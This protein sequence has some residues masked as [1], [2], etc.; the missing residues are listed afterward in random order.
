M[1]QLRPYQQQAVDAAVAHFKKSRK[2]AVVVLP[3]G[4]GKSLV[5]AELGRKARGR[6][7]VLAHVKELVE[8]NHQKFESYRLKA[9][10]F[11]AG[12]ARKE[13]EH[14]ITFGSI[15]SVACNLDAFNEPISLLII[16]ECHRISLNEESSYPL[17]INHFKKLNP[18][19]CVL[20]LTATPFRLGMG[21][22]YNYHYHGMVRTLAP[23]PFYRCIYELP[24]RY[25]LQHGYLTPPMLD[26][27]PLIHYQF[28]EL[29]CA[30]GFFKEKE[31]NQCLQTQKR[32]TPLIM[33]QLL[34][35]ASDRRA[36]MIFAATVKHAREILGFL[37]AN[38][39]ALI[40]GETAEHE[41]DQLIQRFKQQQ[42]K[43]LVNVAVLTTGFDAPHV[44]LIAILRPTESI[45]LYHQI[46]GRGLRLS[47]GKK[48]CLIVD[49]A[50]NRYDLH[51]PEVGE[52]RP[53]GNTEPVQVLCPACGF[54]N[55]FW[56]RLTE[57]GTIIEH[58]GRKC[59]GFL[60]DD[61]GEIEL[62]DYRF[63]F[64]ECRE[65]GAE[66]DIAARQ[67]HQCQATLVD[68]DKQLKEALK[69][70]DTLVIRCCGMSFSAEQE[71][72]TI[73]YHDEDGA[74]LSE[75]FRLDSPQDRR[76]FQQGFLRFHWR[77]PGNEPEFHSCSQIMALQSMFRAPDFVIAR[78][79][80]KRRIICDKLFDY[81]GRYRRAYELS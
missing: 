48:D 22:I 71:K 66:N 52:L 78:M 58:F 2:P 80:K 17:V 7:L 12:L 34:E 4:A 42:L 79:Q 37:P 1:Y 43:F 35:K 72:L 16:D 61:E 77:S 28:S 11:S 67:C 74:E 27:T 50:G 24:L 25:M 73:H 49:Y 57:D 20:G 64:K 65:C 38:Q 76:E 70:Q 15:Q 53:P 59:Q 60:D 81:Q 75:S 14:K 19:L 63:R 29:S 30:E 40:L 46:I 13:S 56:G 69:S 62:C 18:Q 23:R 41:R 31:L 51:Q 36:V 44:D 68:A 32:I 10:I 6:V 54:A 26:D 3:T 5:I 39:S 47:E 8:Q 21:W 9:G 45:S 33:E 55:T